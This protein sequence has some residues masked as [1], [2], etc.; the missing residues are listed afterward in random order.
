M[1]TWKCESC[2]YSKQTR[3][4][5]KKCPD[6]GCSSFEKEEQARD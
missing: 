1:A 5:P 6:C 4:K 3:C 2:G